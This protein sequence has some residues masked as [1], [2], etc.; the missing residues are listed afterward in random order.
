MSIQYR[1]LRP[2]EEDRAVAFW[3]HVLETD[4]IEARQTFRDFSDLPQRFNHAHI[5]IAEDGQIVA[6]VC[7][8]L[9]EVRDTTGAAVP[10]GHLF[11]VATEPTARRQGHASRLLADTV[12]ALSKAGCQW[13]L[14]SA[15][16]DAVAL[17]QRAGWQATPRRYWRGTYAA[18]T[19]P[20]QHDYPVQKY[21]PRQHPNG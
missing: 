3:M 4:D 6:T 16:Q 12:Y 20:K 9:R 15:R 18:D 2:Q 14:L 10:V 8:W 13:A 17:Y 5:A 21:D 11:H 1:L 19:W 7:Y